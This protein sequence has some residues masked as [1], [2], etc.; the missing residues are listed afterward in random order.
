MRLCVCVCVCVVSNSVTLWTVDCQAP[1]SMG[2]S[3]Q[4]NWSRLPFASTGDLPYPGILFPALAGRF[5]TTA[6]PGKPVPNICVYMY[7]VKN[8]PT[9]QET[10]V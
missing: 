1:L 9:M 4:E 5:I 10:W 6:P 3:K 7:L 8:P 2:S